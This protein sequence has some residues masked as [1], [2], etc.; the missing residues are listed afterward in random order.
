MQVGAPWCSL[1]VPRSEDGIGLPT[2]LPAQLLC[3]AAEAQKYDVNHSLTQTLKK[4]L[5]LY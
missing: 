1:A 4:A 5:Q 2:Q 3:A